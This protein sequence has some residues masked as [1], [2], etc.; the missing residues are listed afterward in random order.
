MP[1]ETVRVAIDVMGMPRR[2]ISITERRPDD[3][4]ISAHASNR[5]YLPE[6]E[7]ND[8]ALPHI[9]NHKVSIHPSHDS[10]T[11]INA[12]TDETIEEKDGAQTVLRTSHYTRALKQTDRFAPLYSRY[13]PD[14]TAPEFSGKPNHAYVSLG[15]YDPTKR[16]LMLTAVASNRARAFDPS[17]PIPDHLNAWDHEFQQYRITLFWTFMRAASLATSAVAH[18]PT[19]KPEDKSHPL[20]A[21]SERMA[22]GLDEAMVVAELARI[23]RVL[24]DNFVSTLRY[25]LMMNFGKYPNL[26]IAFLFTRDGG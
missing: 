24:H 18:H 14:L 9:I 3:L 26:P 23:H 10:P 19:V 5:S 2:V 25:R 7:G 6:H 8:A 13:F 17:F 11:M 15:S 4:V 20:H 22:E 12:I 21:V 16:I 1:R